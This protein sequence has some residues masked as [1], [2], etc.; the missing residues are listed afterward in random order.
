MAGMI[1]SAPLGGIDDLDYLMLWIGL[2]G[3]AE[4]LSL[5]KDLAML[6][7]SRVTPSPRASPSSNPGR[8]T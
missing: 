6:R 2:V 4:G 7:E 8:Y 3:S 1:G 5:P